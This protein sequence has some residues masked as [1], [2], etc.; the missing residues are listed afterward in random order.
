MSFLHY[1]G[2]NRKVNTGEYTNG[3]YEV[4]D[5]N[6]AKVIKFTD[7]LNNE[8]CIPLEQIF[9]LTEIKESNIKTYETYEDAASIYISDI[10]T[11]SSNIKRHFNTAYVYQVSPNWGKFFIS[12]DLEKTNNSMYKTNRKCLL[13]LFEFIRQNLIDTEKIE[14]Y[15][16][17]IGEEEQSKNEELSHGIKLDKW[18]LEKDFELKDK[19]YILIEK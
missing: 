5:E 3:K 11:E 1:I 2:L 19:E 6:E 18:V 13:E 10:P 9:D 17:W 7:E 4:K 12:E 8:G 16:C 14:I 15:S